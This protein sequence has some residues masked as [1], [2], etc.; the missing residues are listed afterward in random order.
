MKKNAHVSRR[1]IH[2][3]VRCEGCNGAQ[4]VCRAH[5]HVRVQLRI[6]CLRG[7]AD[8]HANLLKW[9]DPFLPTSGNAHHRPLHA[10]SRREKE[11][12][13]GGGASSSGV[14]ENCNLKLVKHGMR[15]SI[16]QS[17][18]KPQLLSNRLSEDRRHVTYDATIENDGQGVGR[19]G[20]AGHGQHAEGC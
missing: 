13:R 14:R 19:G 3:T 5:F 9:T 15:Q 10:P 8:A 11:N 1:L 17:F 2:V 18:S 20:D 4:H 7:D 12:A 6:K 16:L